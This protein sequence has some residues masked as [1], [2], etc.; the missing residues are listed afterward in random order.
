[1]SILDVFDC[2]KQSATLSVIAAETGLPKP[3]A[4]RL[5]MAL[6]EAGFLCRADPG[7]RLAEKLYVL[8][9]RVPTYQEM[10]RIAR[11]HLETLYETVGEP[12]TLQAM[13]DSGTVIYLERVRTRQCHRAPRQLI[14]RDTP[15]T[16]SG[17]KVLLAYGDR[18]RLQRYLRK[19]LSR[20]TQ[21]S[22]TDPSRLMMELRRT[23][24]HG[25][26]V[27]MEESRLGY[28]SLAVPVFGLGNSFAGAVAVGGTTALRIT[29]LLDAMKDTS[30][31]IS[32]D[33]CEARSSP[34]AI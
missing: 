23:R 16:T 32:R 5:T 13:N 8:G 34:S 27:S 21:Y 20:K 33:L 7:F 3:T 10:S 18:E 28:V 25:Y 15:H 26:A 2:N 4:Y 6:V 22:I 30:A 19:P 12:V 29:P 31:L 11:P 17:G 14:P 1:M 24:R 9:Q